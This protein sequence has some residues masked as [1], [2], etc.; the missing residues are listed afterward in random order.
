[1][2]NSLHAAILITSACLLAACGGPV[3][4]TVDKLGT[5][6]DLAEGS[7]I[8]A[9]WKTV[10]AFDE[11]AAVGPDNVVFAV[12]NAYRIRAEGDAETLAQLRFRA[13]DG[14]LLIGRRDRKW[15]APGG[16]RAARIFVTAPSLRS[17]A[18]A[19]SGDFSA[20]RLAGNSVEL[21]SAG[22]GSIDIASLEAAEVEAE[23][24]GSG[25]IRLS[26]K[27][28]ESDFSVAGSGDI[29]AGGLVSSRADVS[30]AGTGDVRVNATDTVDA[31][32]AGT[33]NITVTGGAKCTSSVIG[34]GKLRCD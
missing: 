9:E 2:R 24:A 8:G 7:A 19:G 15:L 30:I 21:S 10:E 14:K 17:V 25:S 20:D 26:G 1:M 32:I 18:L 13:R 27:T 4:D 29:D 31:S 6:N 22:S 12:G 33:G 11:L 5:S 28:R 3:S 23:L 34:T 16:R